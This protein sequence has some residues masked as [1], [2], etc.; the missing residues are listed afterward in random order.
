M[1][2]LGAGI[3]LKWTEW[4]CKTWTKQRNLYRNGQSILGLK[5]FFRCGCLQNAR[6]G[7]YK[8][9]LTLPWRDILIHDSQ[10]VLNF[11]TSFWEIISNFLRKLWYWHVH[12]ALV[13]LS[14]FVTEKVCS[15]NQSWGLS[16]HFSFN[17]LNYMISP[18]LT[19]WNPEDMSEEWQKSKRK[20]WMSHLMFHFLPSNHSNKKGG[21]RVWEDALEGIR[22]LSSQLTS[23]TPPTTL[24]A[25]HWSLN[26][27][28]QLLTSLYLPLVYTRLP[29]DT[30]FPE[31]S[32]PLRRTLLFLP[33]VLQG[34]RRQ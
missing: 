25:L 27:P 7:K 34:G 21:G 17:A 18:T 9:Y 12:Y 29:K 30:Q 24:R 2:L 3:S 4:N 10:Q 5:L 20:S 23:P 14:N 19:I 28:T 15:Q 8:V 1:S 33:H 11:I 26:P 13:S 31:R 22:C 32:A 6:M 16:P